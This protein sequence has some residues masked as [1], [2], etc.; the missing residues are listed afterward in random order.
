MGLMDTLN[1]LT[2]QLNNAA[3]RL[4]N[5]DNQQVMGNNQVIGNNKGLNGLGNIYSTHENGVMESPSVSVRKI[6][7]DV[8]KITTYIDK[9]QDSYQYTNYFVKWFTDTGLFNVSSNGVSILLQMNTNVNNQPFVA[10]YSVFTCI[11]QAD[12]DAAFKM[13]ESNPI[14]NGTAIIIGYVNFFDNHIAMA[15]RLGIQLIGIEGIQEINSAIDLADNKLPYVAFDKS[16]FLHVLS[17]ALHDKYKS[18]QPINGN[19]TFDN[20]AN[21]MSTSLNNFGERATEAVSGLA[22]GVGLTKEPVCDCSTDSNNQQMEKTEEQLAEE[23][24]NSSM[25][26]CEQHIGGV[27]LDKGTN[28][29]LEKN[30]DT[31]EDVVVNPEEKVGVS[32]GK[33]NGISLSK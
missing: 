21:Q 33:K 24:A 8:R 26:C 30:S 14:N 10:N 28:I 4:T 3:D 2:Q 12:I 11:K 6:E 16:L 32:L 29:S 18:Q 27:S 25:D 7:E 31:K 5:S 9:F 17:S 22:A 19:N 13:L 15:K 1:N 23:L 20:M